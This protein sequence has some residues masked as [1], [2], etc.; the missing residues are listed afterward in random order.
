M[1]EFDGNE[2]WE[3]LFGATK[4]S[5]MEDIT[6]EAFAE[7][8]KAISNLLRPMTPPPVAEP[9]AWLSDRILQECAQQP[10]KYHYALVRGSADKGLVNPV[11]SEATLSAEIAARVKAEEQAQEFLVRGADSLAEL[12]VARET[13]RKLHRRLQAQEGVIAHRAYR[14]A[15]DA[16]WE[17]I[18]KWISKAGKAEA[19]VRE[20]EEALSEAQDQL[21]V[22]TAEKCGS[23]GKAVTEDCPRAMATA[24][25]RDFHGGTRAAVEPKEYRRT[26]LADGQPK[27]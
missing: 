14:T 3:I 13:N 4:G 10:E 6:E 16:L 9:A 11:Y 20:L 15:I 21:A 8:A 24:C 26:L 23:C 18:V 19:R 17:F 5:A 25:W 7:A 27:P 12:E 1:V 2:L 22:A